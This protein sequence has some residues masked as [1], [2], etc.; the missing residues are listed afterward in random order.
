MDKFFEILYI[1]RPA[2]V[3]LLSEPSH[4]LI[5]SATAICVVSCCAAMLKDAESQKVHV[6]KRQS[7]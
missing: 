4:L 7:C 1:H 2:E 6:K 5:F 3:F